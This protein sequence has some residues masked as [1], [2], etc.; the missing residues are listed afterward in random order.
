MKKSIDKKAEKRRLE[1]LDSFT[2]FALKQKDHNT[3]KNQDE[4]EYRTEE[5]QRKN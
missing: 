5:E 1:A 3:N 4:R 2:E